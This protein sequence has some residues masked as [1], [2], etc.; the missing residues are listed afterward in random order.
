[1][2]SAAGEGQTQANNDFG[3]DHEALVTGRMGWSGK[4]EHVNG[5]F[6]SLLNELQESIVAMAKKFAMRLKKLHDEALAKQK[7]AK[8]Q[9]KS[10]IK[11]KP[12]PH[13]RDITGSRCKIFCSF[14]LVGGKF[15]NQSE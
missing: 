4:L 13:K 2:D 15:I 10:H 12:M 14:I 3:H 7:A 11:R 5:A 1:L 6:H 8:L 9:K